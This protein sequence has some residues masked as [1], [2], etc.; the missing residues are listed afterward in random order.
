MPSMS[1]SMVGVMV[2][3]A[4]PVAVRVGGAQSKAGV[5]VPIGAK[6]SPSYATPPVA[7]SDAVRLV[8]TAPWTRA[9]AAR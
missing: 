8:V 1:T 9:T 5:S 4:L 2:A 3:A 6:A 7:L